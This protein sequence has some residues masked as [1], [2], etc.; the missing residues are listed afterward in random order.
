VETKI[1]ATEIKILTSCPS[2]LFG[3]QAGGS[4][5]KVSKKKKKEK[6]SLLAK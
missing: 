4:A 3:F 1:I 6:R 2:L 5:C